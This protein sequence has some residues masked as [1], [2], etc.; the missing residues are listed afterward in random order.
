MIN[1]AV[2]TVCITADQFFPARRLFHSKAGELGQQS[3]GISGQQLIS[4]QKTFPVQAGTSQIKSNCRALFLQDFSNMAS[5]FF[6]SN[7]LP[8]NSS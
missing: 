3:S 6:S 7:V 2:H 5:S 8:E 4:F 1:N